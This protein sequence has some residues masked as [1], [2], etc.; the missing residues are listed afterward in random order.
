MTLLLAISI[1]IN[2][3]YVIDRYDLHF[4]IYVSFSLINLHKQSYNFYFLHLLYISIIQIKFFI[5]LSVS[6]S[7]NFYFFFSILYNET[8]LTKKSYSTSSTYIYKN[9]KMIISEANYIKDFLKLHEI[10]V[11][12]FSDLI[13]ILYYT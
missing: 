13:L 10:I 12:K 3:S 7:Y 11:F 8:I 5:S 6:Y 9:I 1:I 4:H 2:L